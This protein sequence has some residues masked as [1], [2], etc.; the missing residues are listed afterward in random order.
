MSTIPSDDPDLDR[1]KQPGE[2]V[3]LRTLGGH[4]NGLYQVIGADGFDAELSHDA[5][6]TNHFNLVSAR[7]WLPEIR[8]RL[9]AAEEWAKACEASR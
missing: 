9:E 3:V 8:R 4:I 1:T 6:W 7:D 5:G 2:W